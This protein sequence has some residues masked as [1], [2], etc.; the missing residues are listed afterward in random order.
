[1]AIEASPNLAGVGGGGG[2]GG[3]QLK[4]WSALLIIVPYIDGNI[5]SVLNIQYKDKITRRIFFF[6]SEQQP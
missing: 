2:R 6:C 4:M 5:P 1:M 3:F